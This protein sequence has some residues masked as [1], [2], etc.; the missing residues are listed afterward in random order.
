MKLNVPYSIF[1]KEY[2][3]KLNRDSQDYFINILKRNGE[4]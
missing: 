3:E 2:F 1:R 4:L